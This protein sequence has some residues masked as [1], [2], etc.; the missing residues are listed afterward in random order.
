MAHREWRKAGAGML[1][2]HLN[3]RQS[4]NQLF[5]IVALPFHH[6]QQLT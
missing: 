5:L 4:N 1:K 3:K 6:Q 2:I